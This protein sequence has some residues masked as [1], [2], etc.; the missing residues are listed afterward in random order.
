VPERYQKQRTLPDTDVTGKKGTKASWRF[1]KRNGTYYYDYDRIP[2]LGKRNLPKKEDLVETHATALRLQT[3]TSLWDVLEPRIQEVSTFLPA[4]GSCNEEQAVALARACAVVQYAAERVKGEEPTRSNDFYR[5]LA[6]V[7]K[8]HRLTYLPKNYRVLKGK[9]DRVIAGED[10]REVIKLPR[11]HNQNRGKYDNERVIGWM[12]YLRNHG[13]N[14]SGAHIYRKLKRMCEL[15]GE[16]APSKSWV[17]HS[18]AEWKTKFLTGAGRFGSGKYGSDF[19]SYVPIE[20]ALHAGDCWQMDATR[21]Q[22]VRHRSGGDLR[23]LN[24]TVVR[25][26]HSGDIIGYALAHSENRWTYTTALEMAVKATGHLPYEL[27]HDKFP[28]HNTPEWG[29]ISKRLTHQGVKI[30]VTSKATTKAAA[31]RGFGTLQQVVAPD[32]AWYYGEGIMSNNR[33]AHV[34]PEYQLQANKE[35]GREN[36]NFEAA[37]SEAIGIIERY[38][39]TKYSTYS[40]V[41]AK[42]ERTPRELYNDSEQDNVIACD[43]FRRVEIFGTETTGTLRNNGKLRIRIQHVDYLYQLDEVEQYDIIKTYRRVNVC[44]D[45]AD[46]TRVYLFEP[47]TDVNRKY[48]GEVVEERRAAYYGPD[49]DHERIAKMKAKHKQLRERRKADLEEALQAASDAEVM[50]VAATTDKRAVGA[51]ED[52]LVESRLS[53]L[54]QETGTPRLESQPAEQEPT[55]ELPPETDYYT[56]DELD[57]I[58]VPREW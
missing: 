36:F 25:D 26:V 54:L 24:M 35:V 28:G 13:R 3:T 10:V 29:V 22:L 15:T 38:R 7:V 50:L 37:V 52:M 44:Y 16:A 48:L 18:L 12:L 11:Q 55:D 47:G 53:H 39:D 58:A 46:L 31:E 30:T 14:Y 4:Y 17:E 8:D 23:S 20:G 41:R 19:N 5:Q 27:V 45:L 33:N 56:D 1:A 57:L 42:V 9:V 49:A 34:S 6:K 40:R 2:N 43:D 51:T 21:V 32:S